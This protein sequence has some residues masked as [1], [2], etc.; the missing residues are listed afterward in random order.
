MIASTSVLA[1]VAVVAVDASKKKHGC[2]AEVL[3]EERTGRK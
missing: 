3:E 2:E 1:A